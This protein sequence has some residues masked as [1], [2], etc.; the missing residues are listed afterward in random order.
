MTTDRQTDT[1]RDKLLELLIAANNQVKME[2]CCEQVHVFGDIEKKNNRNV[3][4]HESACS[5]DFPTTACV[6]D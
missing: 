2:T 5:K 1:Q 3:I 6:T 4:C